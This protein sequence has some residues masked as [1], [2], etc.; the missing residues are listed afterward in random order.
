[1]SE[2][3]LNIDKTLPKYLTLQLLAFLED[4]KDLDPYAIYTILECSQD[5]FDL[6]LNPQRFHFC[7]KHSDLQKLAS[8]VDHLYL[9]FTNHLMHNI[10]LFDE[11][12]NNRD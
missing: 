2:N 10:T 4:E 11:V 7:L 3:E 12:F 1:M 8:A 6:L 5:H 9:G